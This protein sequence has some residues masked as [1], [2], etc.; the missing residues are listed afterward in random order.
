MKYSQAQMDTLQRTLAYAK[1]HSPFYRE[2]LKDYNAEGEF[3]LDAYRALPTTSKEDLAENN[4]RFCCVD[5]KQIA[6]YVTTSGTTGQ[7]ISLYLTK[8]DLQRLARNERDSLALMG[9]SSGDVVQLLT[10]MDK[11]FMAGL[12]YYLGVQEL[13]AG[14]IRIGPGVPQLQWASIERYKPGYLIAVP[15]F[16]VSLLEYARANNIDFRASSVRG[17]VCIGEPVRNEDLSLNVL[18]KRITEMWDVQLYSTYASTEMGAAFSEC[19]AQQGGHLN[20]DLLFLEVLDDDGNEVANGEAGEIVVTTLDVEGTPL[21]RYRTGD[22][23]H[24]YR[25]TCT[26]GRS[27][28]RL[29]PI[30]GRKNQMIKYKGTTL[31]PKAIFEVFEQFREVSI[32]KVLIEKDELNNDAIHILLDEALKDH[33][34]FDTIRSECSARLRVLPQFS[35]LPHAELF[36]SVYKKH[37]RKPEKILFS[38]SK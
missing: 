19:A 5:R 31:Y 17:I 22:I 3:S 35:F 1:L 2:V 30:V 11:Q 8:N 10:T 4:E 21:I 18:G 20:A 29:G 23:A 14:M 34:I 12:A 13:G 24:V 6:E 27:T 37:L 33:A 36:A 15:S 38:A 26:C 25:T 16:I 32:F 28:P 9:I 7:A